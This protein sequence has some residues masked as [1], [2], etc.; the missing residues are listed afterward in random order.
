MVERLVERP[1]EGQFYEGIIAHIAVLS[2]IK[3]K[4]QTSKVII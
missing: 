2:L 4:S 1:L 3:N